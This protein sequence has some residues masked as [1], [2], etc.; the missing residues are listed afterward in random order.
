MDETQKIPYFTERPQER[1]PIRLYLGQL[2]FSWKRKRLWKEQFHIYARQ[3]KNDICLPHL[4]A[5]HKTPLIRKLRDVDMMLQHNKVHNLI[6]AAEQIN[7]LIVRPGQ[8]FSFWYT[9]GKPTQKKG[10]LK[11]MVLCN[12][13]FKPGIGGGL[14]QLSNLIY[15]MTLHTP[16]TVKERWR[17]NYDVFPDAD[18]TQP[19]GS[20]STVVYNYVDLQITNNTTSN[21]QLLLWLDN[22]HLHGEWRSDQAPLYTYQVYEKEHIITREWWGGYVRHNILKRRVYDRNGQELGDDFITENHAFMMYEPM[23]ARSMVIKK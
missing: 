16:L 6:L 3:K 7:G 9:V 11:G 17:H 13:S 12:G 2:Y 5:A 4:A 23:L 22:E 15:W 8:T 20:G 10:Y 19:F 21:Y 1:S 14:C 18:R